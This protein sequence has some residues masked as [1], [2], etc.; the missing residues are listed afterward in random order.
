MGQRVG[1]RM[2]I[3]TKKDPRAV[4][5]F[6]R[7]LED[8]RMI[9]EVWTDPNGSMPA[10]PLSEAGRVMSA[11]GGFNINPWVEEHLRRLG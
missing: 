4:H 8:H 6:T 1:G 3:V 7:R 9:V 10:M 11:A 5:I 2:L